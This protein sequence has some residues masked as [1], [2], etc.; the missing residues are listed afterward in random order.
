MSISSHIPFHIHLYGYNSIA[1]DIG[2]NVLKLFLQRINNLFSFISDSIYPHHHTFM[3]QTQLNY[4]GIKINSLGLFC[5]LFT[6]RKF[7]FDLIDTR[8]AMTR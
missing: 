3:H 4:V 7:S 5:K 1:T 8:I 6:V 2:M